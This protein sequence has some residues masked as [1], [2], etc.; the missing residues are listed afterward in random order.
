MTDN[1]AKAFH[2]SKP[3]KANANVLT[4]LEI[5]DY[6]DTAE[7]LGYLPMF[8]LVLTAGLRHTCAVLSLQNGMET[9]ELARMLGHARTIMTLQNYAP[10]LLHKKKTT[11]SPQAKYLKPS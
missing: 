6:L 10:Y 9:K 4:P 1:P 2:Y 7:R 5:E 11:E 8:M 3:K